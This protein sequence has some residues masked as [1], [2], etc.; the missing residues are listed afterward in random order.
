LK[1]DAVRF[2]TE[3]GDGVELTRFGGYLILCV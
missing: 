2:V 1:R 3:Q